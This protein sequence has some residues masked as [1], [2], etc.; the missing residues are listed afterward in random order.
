[1]AIASQLKTYFENQQVQTVSVHLA[2]LLGEF[3][4]RDDAVRQ[5]ADLQKSDAPY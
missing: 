3:K 4:P 2:R 1:L 5:K